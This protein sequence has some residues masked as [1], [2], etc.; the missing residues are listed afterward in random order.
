MCLDQNRRPVVCQQPDGTARR[1]RKTT[2]QVSEKVGKH[3]HKSNSWVKNRSRRNLAFKEHFVIHNISQIYFS[4]TST[5]EEG[6]T[7][8]L[9]FQSADMKIYS[10]R[11]SDLPNVTQLVYVGT[12]TSF[13]YL[14]VIIPLLIFGLSPA[15]RY[16]NCSLGFHHFSWRLLLLL[17]Y[18]Y[19]RLYDCTG[20]WYQITEE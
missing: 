18:L 3:F 13:C 6:W 1:D 5:C 19:R 4:S 12:S 20:I 17:K 14:R 16:W 11:L 10:E 2:S 15:G 7:G 9:P 8:S